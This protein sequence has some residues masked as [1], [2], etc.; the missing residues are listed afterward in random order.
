MLHG[1]QE[2]YLACKTDLTDKQMRVKQ[3]CTLW[4]TCTPNIGIDL[5]CH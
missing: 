2:F 1:K 4:W 3:K 5:M